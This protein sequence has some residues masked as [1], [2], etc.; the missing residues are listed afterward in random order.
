MDVSAQLKPSI[1][2][3]AASVIT[4]AA[5]LLGVWLTHLSTPLSLAFGFAALVSAT[6]HWLWLS[7]RLPQS[8]QAIRYKDGQWS[9]ELKNGR[10]EAVQLTRNRVVLPFLISLSFKSAHGNIPCVIFIDAVSVTEHR[11]LR[12][13]VI[14]EPIVPSQVERRILSLTES[15]WHQ[16][17]IRWLGRLQRI[18]ERVM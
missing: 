16:N 17:R 18:V 14:Q 15:W 1:T 7:G 11:R 5:A 3:Q 8:V 13:A 9:V 10:T 6:H 12:S 2:L 4:L